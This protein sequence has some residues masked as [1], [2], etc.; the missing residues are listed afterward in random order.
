MLNYA[1]QLPKL[2]KDKML[3]QK[4]DEMFTKGIDVRL[5]NKE[6]YISRLKAKVSSGQMIFLFD[7]IKPTTIEEIKAHQDELWEA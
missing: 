2:H 5:L 4:M 6:E 3:H 1:K 7:P